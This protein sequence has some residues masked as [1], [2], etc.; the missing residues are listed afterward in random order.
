MC[1]FLWSPDDK[2]GLVLVIPQPALVPI[3]VCAP[4]LHDALPIFRRRYVLP[5]AWTRPGSAGI[6]MPSRDWTSTVSVCVCWAER[7]STRLNSS[8]VAIS[9][10]VFSLKKKNRIHYRFYCSI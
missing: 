10:A 6:W 2:K 7:K 4:S 5:M 3:G 9:Y 8:H 1:L